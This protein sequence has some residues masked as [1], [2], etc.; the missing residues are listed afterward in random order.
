MK[1]CETGTRLDEVIGGIPQGY[2]VLLSGAPGTGKTVFC[3]H[4][5]AHGAMKGEKG[6]LITTSAPTFKNVDYFSGF[7]FYDKKLLTTKA[8][9]FMDFNELAKDVASA[10]KGSVRER[11]LDALVTLV[12]DND[13]KRLVIDS[14]TGMSHRFN[15]ELYAF[16]FDLSTQLS[17]LGCTAILTNEAAP[18]EGLYMPIPP[19]DFVA[20][21]VITLECAEE[22][23]VRNRFLHVKKMR[24]VAVPRRPIY[25]R[26]NKKGIDMLPPVR[27]A[28]DY[29]LSG[30]RA[31]TGVKGLDAMLGGGLFKGSTA[32]VAGSSGTGKTVLCMHAAQAS[33]EKGMSVVFA[34]FEE[35]ADQLCRQAA[36]FGWDFAKQL[37]AGRL[38]VYAAAPAEADLP[39]HIN[40]IITEMD[41]AKPST[42]VLDSISALQNTFGREHARNALTAL[43][44][45]C[46]R[47]HATLIATSTTPDILKAGRVAEGHLST[48]ADCILLLKYAE[49]NS[50]MKR[51]IVAL[52]IRGSAHDKGIREFDIGGKGIEL[53]ERFKGVQGLMGGT[54]TKTPE[55]KFV[56]AFKR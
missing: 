8:I 50:E 49:M 48:I 40:R 5:L 35:S 1:F 51:L 27:E 2:L 36:S 37:K 25:F 41:E 9:E 47:R 31:G 55:E 22:R 7:E 29:A 45:E 20:D 53:K 32:L 26:I 3:T 38:R 23:G 15:S 6:M 4:F 11:M 46:K 33:L 54:P 13:V 43:N 30:E 42:V 39:E 44:A 12:R 16:L 17:A 18:G 28:L 21:G 10:G 56:E 24:G 52:K 14:V 19:E 34:S